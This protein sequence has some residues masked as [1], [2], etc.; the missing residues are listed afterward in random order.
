MVAGS[1]LVNTDAAPIR[2]LDGLKPHDLE[3]GIEAFLNGLI[4]PVPIIPP[5]HIL[6]VQARGL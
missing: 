1:G 5:G 2:K 3:T 4:A 6:T